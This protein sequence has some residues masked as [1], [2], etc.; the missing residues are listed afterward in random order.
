MGIFAEAAHIFVGTIAYD[1]N[2]TLNPSRRI[3]DR[4]FRPLEF[5]V[6]TSVGILLNGFSA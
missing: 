2:D 5:S 1:S 3:Y 6:G 4:I